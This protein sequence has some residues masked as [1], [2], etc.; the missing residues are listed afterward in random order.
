MPRPAHTERQKFRAWLDQMRVLA[1][2]LHSATDTVAINANRHGDV[3]TTVFAAAV[4]DLA[5]TVA[6]HLDAF[7]DVW[8][9]DCAFKDATE[10]RL[11]ALE[12]AVGRGHVERFRLVKGEESQRPSNAGEAPSAESPVPP[13]PGARPPGLT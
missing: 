6:A 3:E 2:S 8:A 9:H 1:E 10:M 5:R 7:A 12:G 13:S 4:A 11:D